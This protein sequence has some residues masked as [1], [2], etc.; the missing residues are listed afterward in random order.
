MKGHKPPLEKQVQAEVVQ[1]FLA[2]GCSVRSLSQYRA[3]MVSV[4][5]PDLLVMHPRK[6]RWF[7][8]EVKRP[9]ACKTFDRFK[10]S[11]WV[12]EPL[13]MPQEAFRE[14]CRSTGQPHY[15]GGF[16]EAL[17]ALV[18]EGLHRS[19]QSGPLQE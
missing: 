3:S 6:G 19:T 16:N 1:L 17:A 18:A 12:P 10:R 4:G 9:K 5:L 13:R 2:A 8:F 15:F 14:D 7:W 11:T